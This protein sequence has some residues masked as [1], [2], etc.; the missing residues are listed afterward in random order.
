LKFI[1]F[2]SIDWEIIYLGIFFQY[3]KKILKFS[4]NEKI[5]VKFTRISHFLVEKK[6]NIVQI[7]LD[8]MVIFGIEIMDFESIHQ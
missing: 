2:G 6:K 3:C 1:D 7:N 5:L 4:Q 8:Y